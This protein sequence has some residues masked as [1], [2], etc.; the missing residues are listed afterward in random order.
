M[1]FFRSIKKN[2]SGVPGGWWDRGV[3]ILL[4]KHGPEEEE[5]RKYLDLYGLF[6]FF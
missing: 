1:S 5:H 6:Q 2:N 3:Q 4:S